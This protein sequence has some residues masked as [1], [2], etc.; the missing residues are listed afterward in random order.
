MGLTPDWVAA[1]FDLGNTPARTRFH[2]RLVMPIA[3]IRLAGDATKLVASC[4]RKAWATGT[5]DIHFWATA[6][7]VAQISRASCSTQ[8][9]CGNICR[10]SCWQ[11]AT[12]LPAWSKS[13]ARDDVV[14]WSSASM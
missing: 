13:M 12:A 14:P 11:V 7:C 6:S 8:P 5:F 10:N 3:K 4:N 2:L 9:G 1:P